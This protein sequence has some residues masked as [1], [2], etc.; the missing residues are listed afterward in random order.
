MCGIAGILQFERHHGPEEMARFAQ[1]MAST[2]AHRG[3]D[4]AGVW[5]SDDGLCALSHRRLSI[6]EPSPVGHQPMHAA[7]GRAVISFNGEIYNYLE[8]RPELEARGRRL[9]T[10]TDTEVLIEAVREWGGLAFPRLDGMYAFALYDLDRR[11]LWLARDAF[12]EKPLYYLNDGKR[13]AFASELHALQQLPFFDASIAEEGLAEYLCFTYVGAPRTLYRNVAKLPPGSYLRVEADGRSAV[14]RYFEFAPGREPGQEERSLDDLSDELEEIL[15]RLIRRRLISDVPLGAFLSGGVDSSTVCA[16]VR[17]KLGVPLETFSIGFV[18]SAES[19]HEQAQRYAEYLGTRHHMREI[20]PDATDFLL[21]AGDHL[22]EPNGD[23]SCLPT[24]LLSAF[25]R[26]RVT[27]AVSGDGGDEM[28][29]GYGRYFHALRRKTRV[30]RRGRGGRAAEVG[31]F[32]YDGMQFFGDEHL[33]EL[34]GR[35]PGELGAHL[36]RLRTY[37]ERDHGR[38]DLLMRLRK[39]DVDHYLPGAVLAKVDRMSMQHGLEVRT[40]FL[41]IELARFAEK[42]PTSA[43]YRDNEGKVLLKHLAARYLPREWL[44]LPKRGFGLPVSQAWG[45]RELLDVVGSLLEDGDSVLAGALGRDRVARFLAR[46][47]DPKQ[48]QIYQLWA[49]GIL[50]SYLRRRPATLPRGDRA[51]DLIDLEVS[52]IHPLLARLADEASARGSELVVFCGE[53]VPEGWRKMPAKI[54]LVLRS[55]L[56]SVEGARVIRADWT[57]PDGAGLGAL[58]GEIAVGAQAVFV[59]PGAESLL[60]PNYCERLA[61]LGFASVAVSAP[62]DIESAVI[63][64]SRYSAFARDCAAAWLPP[65]RRIGS[66]GHPIRESAGHRFRSRLARSSG[67]TSDRFAV[68]EGRRPLLFGDASAEEIRDLGAGRNGVD[69]RRVYFSASDNSDPRYNRRRYRLVD[70]HQRGVAPWWAPAP[71]EAQHREAVVRWIDEANRRAPPA[72]AP[73]E[74]DTVALVVQTLF[75]GG[76]ERQWVSLGRELVSRGFRVVLFAFDLERENAHYLR[77]AQQAA[78]EV[79]EMSRPASLPDASPAGP[80]FD[81]R[82]LS[83][84]ATAPGFL[85]RDLW[86]L[87]RDLNAI[88]ASYV[89]CALDV[90]NVCGGLAGLLGG[91]RRVLLSFRNV[92]PT[93][94][95][96]LDR[97]W[98]RDYYRALAGSQ[99]IV[100]SG[101]SHAGNSDYAEWLGIDPQRIRTIHNGFAPELFAG[102]GETQ[103]ADLRAALEIAPGA[104]IVCGLFRWSDEKDPDAFLEVSRRLVGARDDVVV[105]QAGGGPGLEAARRRVTGL[106]LERRIRL[107]GT[108]RDVG[109]LMRASQLLLSTSR[110]EGLPNVMLEAQ[111]FGLPVVATAVGGSAEAIE[112]GATGVLVPPGDVDAITRACLELLDDPERRRA[113]GSAGEKRIEQRFS[114]DAFID[115]TLD[116]LSEP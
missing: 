113:L 4:D 77:L 82:V 60:T 83:L 18:G 55:E 102:I 110:F 86:R 13:L 34:F 70:L 12:G 7:D 46:Q 115:A 80:A 95:P 56:A 84:A 87:T 27:V 11:A 98:L 54:A 114:V 6:I 68:T 61:Q 69:G 100:W 14:Q 92:N 59:V 23:S 24:F 29:G 81:P 41:S 48:T 109:A 108:R 53:S 107:L 2:I 16:L 35:V 112:D 36:D 39:T 21:H 22:D 37:V 1:A 90:P 26:E 42:L 76:A 40:P 17:K 64:L 66:F 47:R 72:R 79:R 45:Q 38:P 85:R 52:S 91:A 75:A 28:F 78:V 116:A 71:P 33:R 94:F 20:A 51:P 97:P 49:I 25:A 106:G 10:R 89:A 9:R 57:V 31:R 88:G 96:T 32:Y 50:E 65:G 15:V 30:Q 101:N 44:D 103:A 3:P 62:D 5:V 104:R 43:L 67:E 93:H 105:V 58:E 111:H 73:R 19:E 63:D 74:G 8:L 99:Q